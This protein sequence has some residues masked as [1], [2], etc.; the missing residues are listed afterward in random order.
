M[1][2]PELRTVQQHAQQLRIDT[3]R[4]DGAGRVG[5]P[6]AADRLIAQHG[7]EALD[8]VNRRIAAAIDRREGER[9][10]LMFR[11]R[12][13]VAKLQAPPRGPL[14]QFGRASP[15]VERRR[16][17][18]GRPYPRRPEVTLCMEARCAARCSLKLRTLGSE[19]RSASG[20]TPPTFTAGAVGR[21]KRRIR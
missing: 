9:V 10:L 20:R 5:L 6:R 1:P 8:E 4:A 17:E 7:E 13:A 16:H 2:W 3:P 19:D 11:V 18:N 14:H 21:R 15:P 12:L